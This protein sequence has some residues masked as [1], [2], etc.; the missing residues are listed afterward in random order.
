LG[1]HKLVYAVV[2][3]AAKADRMTWGLGA[4]GAGRLA[5]GGGGS[6]A[7]EGEEGVAWSSAGEEGGVGDVDETEEAP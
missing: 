7:G 2:G 5:A 6:A 3:M 1:F 4:V